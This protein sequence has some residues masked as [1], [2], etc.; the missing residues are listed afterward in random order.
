MLDTEYTLEPDG[1]Q[2]DQTVLRMSKVAVGPMTADE[3]DGIRTFGDISRFEDALRAL[4]E[5]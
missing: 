5:A 3:A 2:G 4:V 1:D